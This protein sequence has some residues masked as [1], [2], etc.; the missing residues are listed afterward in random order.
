MENW[1]YVYI[2]IIFLIRASFGIRCDIY[3]FMID[4]ANF[5]ICTF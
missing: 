2:V 4:V 1:K 5:K 3:T